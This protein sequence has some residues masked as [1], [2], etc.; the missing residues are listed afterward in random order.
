METKL[1]KRKCIGC[2][3]KFKLGFLFGIQVDYYRMTGFELLRRDAAA[4]G[5]IEEEEN[6]PDTIPG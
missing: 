2:C 1:E 6:P 4:M 5:G 3:N